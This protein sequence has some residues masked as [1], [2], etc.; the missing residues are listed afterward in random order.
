MAAYG[1]SPAGE[2]MPR[3]RAA[4]LRALAL[5]DALAEAHASLGLV[6]L[7]Y[8]WDWDESERRFR[9]ALALKPGLASAHHWFA[10]YLM[11]RGRTEEALAELQ[12]AEELDP[13]SLIVPTDRGRALYF[14]RRRPEAIAACRRALDGDPAFVPA[15]ITEGMVLED[16]GQLTEALAAFEAVVRLTGDP[17][18]RALVARASALA[19]RRA[20]GQRILDGLTALDGQR[21]VSPYSLAL[22]YAALGRKDDAFRE[23]NRAVDERSS[24]MAYA[25]VN[26]RLDSLRGDP[27]F[28]EVRRRI[29][30]AR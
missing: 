10:E 21:Y 18:H 29:A 27:R 11:A 26:P 13:L 1:V 12:R 19:G 20:E 3:A 30:P 16:G 25:D 5:D 8:D 2:S 17:Q 24:W 7:L 9:R 4:A 28:E 15:L 22:V 6:K 23:L 14:A